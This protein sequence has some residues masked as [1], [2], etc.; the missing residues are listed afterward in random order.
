MNART[1]SSAP[2]AVPFAVTQPDR[3]PKQRYYDKEFYALECERFWPRVWQMACR[4]EEIPRRG[5][6]V[7]YEILDQSIILTRID[8]RTIKAYHNACRHRGVQLLSDRG[9]RPNGIRCPFHGWSWNLNGECTFV[10]TPEAFD[11]RNLDRNDLRLREC[12]VE[13][14][15][16]CAFINL[17][18]DAPP[19]RDSIEPFATMHD[20]W[21]A[22][23]LRTEW[24][25][26]ARMPCNWKLAM[27]AFMEGYH[28]MQTHPQLLASGTP[29]GPGSAYR[30]VGEDISPPS[31]Y[32]TIPTE[33]ASSFDPRQ[34]IDTNIR[35]MKLLSVGMAGMTH[36]KDVLVAESLRGME[37]PRTFESAAKTW[38]R[39]LNDAVVAWHKKQDMDVADLNDL[40]AAQGRF[41]G[42]FLLPALLHASDREQ[43]IGLSH[44]AAWTG[45]MPVRAVVADPLSRGRGAASDQDADADG[46]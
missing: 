42:K 24:W 26:S 9:N 43:R 15:G 10:F 29:V 31:R 37:L 17:D 5:D 33:P 25:L 45:G 22:E 7:V 40:Y 27:E 39:A 41:G 20:A 28:V 1:G 46:A 36:E 11:N 38:N 18:D 4:L 6:Y 21:H 35:M 8:E 12:R 3:I 14:W 32:A 2:L 16:G 34:Y 30:V 44:S 13:C 19:L 23:T